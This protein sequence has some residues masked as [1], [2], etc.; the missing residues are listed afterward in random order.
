MLPGV[1]TA[2][3][4]VREVWFLA[5]DLVADLLQLREQAQL[6]CLGV[7]A[8]ILERDAHPL[9][10][11]VGPTEAYKD[12]RLLPDYGRLGV[13]GDVREAHQPQRMAPISSYMVHAC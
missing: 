12:A 13:A 6:G 5:F 2:T 9:F 11:V 10:A 1:G 4:K 7:P 8:D 3:L